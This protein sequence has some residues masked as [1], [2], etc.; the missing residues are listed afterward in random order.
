MA[1][2]VELQTA[3]NMWKVL[4]KPGDAVKAGEFGFILLH[5]LGPSLSSLDEIDV[6]APA[7]RCMAA[8]MSVSPARPLSAS[9]AVCEAPEFTS[10]I[11]PVS[12]WLVAEI[13]FT[14]AAISVDEAPKECM[15]DSCC[16]AVAAIC[17]AV[18]I[19]SMLDRLISETKSC[20]RLMTVLIQ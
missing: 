18:A 10:S 17:V 12:C 11:V 6:V 3:G 4:V 5:V 19:R 7:K 2:E 13:S 20:N 9:S 8:S 14:A 1:H 15:F 16:L